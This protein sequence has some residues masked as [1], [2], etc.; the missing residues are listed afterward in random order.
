[1]MRGSALS[2]L[3]AAAGA[4]LCA[5]LAAGCGSDGTPGKAA[6]RPD[7]LTVIFSSDLLGNIRSCGCAIKDMGGLG[8][9]ASFAGDVRASVDNLIVVDAGDAF[10]IDLSFTA[11]EAELAFDAIGV[12]GL[13]A[14]TPGETEFVFGLPF[15][16]GV[17]NHAAFPIVS[18]NIVD[19]VSGQRIFGD[20]YRIKVLKGGLRVAIVG[21]LDDAIRFPAYIDASKFKVLPAVETLKALLP[22]MKAKADFL[23]LLSHMGMDRSRELARE[24]GDF[25][26]VVVGHGK[27]SIKKLEKEGK[28]IML[29]TGGS[30]KFLG[31]ID[32][33]LSGKGDI[34]EGQMNL[35][36]L[37][38][39][40]ALDRRV[41]ELFEQ[42]GVSLTDKDRDKKE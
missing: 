24:I 31:Q 2:R 40:I 15:L 35:V 23:I 17:A 18:A 1:M 32:L 27:P 6:A 26:L 20:A 21:V 39:S 10:G 33:S 19:P 38:D 5:A 37:E 30:G 7:K 16:Q 42:Y 29:A 4:I 28:T 22:E 9:W 41:V 11:K 14:F 8:R 13:D 3:L 36:P 25:D 34:L 12:V